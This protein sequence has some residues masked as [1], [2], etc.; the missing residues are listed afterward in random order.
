MARMVE[1]IN[2]QTHTI[3]LSSPD[4]TIIKIPGRG[5]VVLSDWY[6]NYCPKYLRVVRVIDDTDKTITPRE[7]NKNTV[8]YTPPGQRT[9]KLKP[10]ERKPALQVSGEVISTEAVDG[11]MRAQATTKA[12]EDKPNRRQVVGRKLREDVKRLFSQ[13]C[14]K[15]EWTVSNNI[16]IGI[17]SFNR[18]KSL[19]RL[20]H[21][22]RQ[23][24]D[25]SRTTVFVS[26]ESTDAEVKTWLRKQTDIVVLTDQPR[27]GIAGNTNRLLRCLNRFKYGIILNDDV[28]IVR[29]GWEEFYR[30]AAVAT[31]YHHFCYQQIGVYGAKRDGK[32]TTAGGHKL[33]TINDKPHGAVMFF[34]NE[35]FKKVGYFDEQ[36]GMYGM[37][38]VDWSDRISACGIQ[39]KGF[40]DVVGSDQFFRIHQEPS[41][42]PQRTH[43]LQKARAV[44]KQVNSSRR[45][46]VNASDNSSV[47]SISVVIPI[48]E[49]GRQEALR[50]IVDSMRSQLFPNIE[51]IVVEQDDQPRVQLNQLKPCRHFF[52]K[53]K[54][55]KQPFTKAMAFNLGIANISTQRVILQD[56][57]IVCPSNYV[58]KIYDLL[59]SYE[60]IH[61]GS[62]VLYMDK[63][64]TDEITTSNKINKDKEC[65]RAVGYFEGGSLACTKSAYFRVGA[66]NE[67]FEG[68]GVEDC[69]FFERLK[70]QTKFYNERTEDFV[71]LWHGRTAGWEQH[72]RRNKKIGMQLKKQYNMASYIASLVKKIKSTYPEIA[73]ELGI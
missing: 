11:K 60:G 6:L 20:L 66:F 31:N 2:P 30:N 34:T 9:S 45:L 58:A 13:A 47:P 68:Y 27:L 24:T 12:N 52:A 44:Y 8:K 67:I 7:I 42:V 15:N 22:I 39:P 62:K 35:A 54:Y 3:Q 41:M 10:N 53:N 72:H 38:H 14:Q 43:E 69:D 26:D 50:V 21:S 19:Q 59:N 70:Y 51:I 23:N 48:R 61:I 64:S 37:E 17:L 55:Q 1:Y 57:D 16:G 56:A 4:R 32:T 5:K 33:M 29:R 49:I 28:E 65:E 46:F 40:H 36:F 25:L 71:H 73:K 63:T 18:L